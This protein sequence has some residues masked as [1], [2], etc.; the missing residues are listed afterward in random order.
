VLAAGKR[1]LTVCRVPRLALLGTS[2]ALPTPNRWGSSDF[3]ARASR[4]ALVRRVPDE[5]RSCFSG[6]AAG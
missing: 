6:L 4:K 2:G 1:D 5:D 3:W